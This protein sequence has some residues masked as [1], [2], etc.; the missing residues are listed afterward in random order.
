MNRIRG[1][2]GGRGM[3]LKLV[4]RASEQEGLMHVNRPRERNGLIGTARGGG[5][6]SLQPIIMRGMNAI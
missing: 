3:H 6:A 2:D 4:A 5:R 1:R